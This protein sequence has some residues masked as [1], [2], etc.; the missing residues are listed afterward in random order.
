MARRPAQG[1]TAQP[2]LDTPEDDEDEDADLT[3]APSVVIA[4]REPEDPHEALVLKVRE[5]INGGAGSASVRVSLSTPGKPR[6]YLGSIP[7]SR[8]DVLDYQE[9]VT[10][11][12]GGSGAGSFYCEFRAGG[13]IEGYL[14][15]AA[16]GEPFP[17]RRD[18]PGGASGSTTE[19]PSE[20]PVAPTPPPAPV[21][22][23]E[24]IARRV[25]EELLREQEHRELER[26]RAENE[27]LKNAPLAPVLPSA[28]A[29]NPF[30]SIKSAIESLKDV[31]SPPAPR[32]DPRVSALEEQLKEQIKRADAAERK[33]RE[34]EIEE[35]QKFNQKLL[36]AIQKLR[37]K[38]K[39]PSPD[40]DAEAKLLAFH[41][42]MKIAQAIRE[43]GQR[44]AEETG[45]PEFGR[46][47]SRVAGAF[48]A[49]AE[50]PLVEFASRI[51]DTA[52]KALT[53]K[54]EE[55]LAKKG[56]SGFKAVAFAIFQ[57]PQRVTD[58]AFV[59]DALAKCP[60][61]I[62]KLVSIE[63]GDREAVIAFA[64][65]HMGADNA[66]R[67]EKYPPENFAGLFA[68]IAAL[69][70]TVERVEAAAQKTDAGDEPDESDDQG[71]E[72]EESDDEADDDEQDG[73]EDEGA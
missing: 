73:E 32:V 30:D 42:R 49:K 70:S 5:A 61:E 67:I 52:T 34:K 10:R 33:Q 31:I 47:A 55:A 27:R 23:P 56:S 2:R 53:D 17:V 48:L 9:H 20:R 57:Q 50:K 37:R 35:Q 18:P 19:Q 60:R 71:D 3:G 68:V 59:R 12:F 66:A 15:F 39:A 25:R 65:E 64:R 29:P 26:L 46:V 6:V 41:S 36:G 28:P 22:D 8:E 24:A 4:E 58:E 69:R 54:A 21:V 16:A 7:L 13:R 45:D 1:R 62:R 63:N 11:E 40:E 38:K 14:T 51:G 43:D 44:V 72:D